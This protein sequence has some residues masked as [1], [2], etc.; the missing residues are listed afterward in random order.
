M[1][2]C[3]C[4]HGSS[5]NMLNIGIF[6]RNKA[7]SWFIRGRLVP[8]RSRIHNAKIYAK[9]QITNKWR[10]E[11]KHRTWSQIE[12]KDLGASTIRPDLAWNTSEPIKK[13]MLCRLASS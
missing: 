7:T 1:I 10:A 11:F 13:A 8:A 5:L 12:W 2:M 9:T 3:N 4:V 6:N